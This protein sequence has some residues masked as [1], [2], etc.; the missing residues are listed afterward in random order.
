M[1]HTKAICLSVLVIFVGCNKGSDKVQSDERDK[2]TP[3]ELEE[4]EPALTETSRSLPLER[5]TLPPGFEISVFAEVDNAR[6][7]AI[8]P[9]GIIY[10]GNR[11]GG[12]VYAV[13]DSDGDFKAD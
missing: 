6:S 11:N 3:S 9:S 10:I 13:Q 4:S 2:T 5:I 12:K 1:R 7:L 8:S